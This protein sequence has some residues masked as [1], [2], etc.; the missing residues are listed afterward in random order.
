MANEHDEG[1]A[2]RTP[3]WQYYKP[4]LAALAALNR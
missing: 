2:E 4:I 1:K 3:L